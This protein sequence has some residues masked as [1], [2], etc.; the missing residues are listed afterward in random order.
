RV[1]GNTKL[2]KKDLGM[3]RFGVVLLFLLLA[4][5]IVTA[6]CSGTVASTNAVMPSISTQPTNQMV[7]PGQA[8]TFS[9]VATGAAPLSYQWQKNAT[10]ISGATAA[11]YTTPATTSADNGAQFVVVVSDPA[12]SVTS[13]AATLT[14]SASA[15][16]PTMTTQ[17]A[18]QT[19][20]VGQTAAFTV[21]ATGT[22]PLSY[23]WQK[24]GTAITGATSATY[25]TPATTSADN[26]AQFVVM[27]NNS[28]GSVTSNA[29]TLTVNSR[30]TTPTI[31]T[32]PANQT[33][34]ASQTT[35]YTIITTATAP[36]SDKQQ[37]NGT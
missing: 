30:A 5:G 10:A 33:E 28:V 12:G 37:K 36:P 35:T 2:R 1:P 17:P 20:T 26:S 19:V 31:T 22:A 25:T 34:T 4:I 8:A 14:V 3:N 29:A 32:Q 24:N 9:V 23:Q 15:T 21:V 27:V 7:T 13:N 6:G 18:N 11:V 16:A